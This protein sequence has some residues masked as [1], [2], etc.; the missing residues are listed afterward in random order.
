MRTFLKHHRV[1][2]LVYAL[3]CVALWQVPLFRVL[4]VESCAVLA[5]V[6]FFVSGLATLRDVKIQT[7]K[8]S[9]TFEVYL[10]RDQLALLLFPFTLMNF[11]MLWIPNCDWVNGWM[12]FA[13]FPVVSTIFATTLAHLIAASL[14]SKKKT[15]FVLLGLFIG[16][17]GA[18]YDIGLQ[19]QFYTY[20]PVFGGV[21]GPIY[22]EELAIRS[23]IFASKFIALLWA[24]LFWRISQRL[25]SART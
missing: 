10:L 4:H 5:T 14:L 12:F 19:P 20:N 11:G 3:T 17:G 23:G 18:L 25:I 13:L 21:L 9:K 8:V 15:V 16:I 7:L 24:L 6:T 1:E 22:D 2:I